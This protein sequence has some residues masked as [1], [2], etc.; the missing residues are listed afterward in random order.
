[1]ALAGNSKSQWHSACAGDDRIAQ[2]IPIMEYLDE[3]FGTEQH[4]L[5]PADL[6]GRA[7]VRAISQYIISEIQPLQS[8]R[9]D[10]E[11]KRLVGHAVHGTHA[12]E[13]F[14]L[15]QLLPC[16]SNRHGC[17][18]IGLTHADMCSAACG[19]EG[20]EEAL[21]HSWVSAAGSHAEQSRDR[22]MLPRRHSHNGR[23][24]PRS[25]GASC[26]HGMKSRHS[27]SL[28]RFDMAMC[29]CRCG[30]LTIDTT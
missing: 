16:V 24:L 5:L 4:A 15:P 29:L 11:L 18:T 28:R 30:M 23:L 21:D 26:M 1:M 22:Q 25:P 7:R 20:M 13:A 9:A 2:S 3:R 14:C 27:V 10:A 12:C 17:A 6:A 19:R 8:T